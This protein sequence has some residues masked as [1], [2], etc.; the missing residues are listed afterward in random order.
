MGGTVNVVQNMYSFFLS[1]VKLAFSV[2]VI[3]EAVRF[4]QRREYAGLVAFIVIASVV[5][6][7]IWTEG[8]PLVMIG[9]FI[10][11][12]LTGR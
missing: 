11:S 8:R 12:V 2:F 4:V 1:V 5:A 3:Y 10:L 6:M 9:E 7:I